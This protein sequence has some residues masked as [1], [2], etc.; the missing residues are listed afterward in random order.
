MT[1]AFARV[2]PNGPVPATFLAIDYSGLLGWI[3]RPEAAREDSEVV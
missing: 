2:M 3:G 1:P